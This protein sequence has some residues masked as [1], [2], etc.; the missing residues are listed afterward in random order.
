M[1]VAND[2]AALLRGEARRPLALAGLASLLVSF[3]SAV[4]VLAL[5]AIAADF[6]APVAELDAVTAVNAFLRVL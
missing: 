2:A 5:P 6:R 1:A 4:L 3:D